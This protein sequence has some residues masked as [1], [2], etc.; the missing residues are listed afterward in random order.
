MNI[1]NTYNDL[2]KQCSEFINVENTMTVAEVDQLIDI[3]ISVRK[4]NYEDGTKIRQSV[5]DDYS[6]L[7]SPSEQYKMH[8][9]WAMTTSYDDFKDVII[10][11]L[12]DKSIYNNIMHAIELDKL[13][14]TISDIE[15]IPNE[16][17]IYCLRNFD[18]CREQY[19]DE[20][21][22]P[23][24][25]KCTNPEL[26][27]VNCLSVCNEKSD[28][29]IKIGQVSMPCLRLMPVK[30]MV[31]E[32]ED[33]LDQI[34]SY[35]TTRELSPLLGAKRNLVILSGNCKNQAYDYAD[36]KNTYI[37][38]SQFCAMTLEFPYLCYVY[39][40][41]VSLDVEVDK[42]IELKAFVG[43]DVIQL[44]NTKI[45]PN[46]MCRNVKKHTCKVTAPGPCTYMGL[47]VGFSSFAMVGYPRV[48]GRA[49]VL[50]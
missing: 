9:K 32:G 4:L 34:Y 28:I 8:L 13:H 21:E 27:L 17:I 44:Q 14:F 24:A 23:K 39:P 46:N 37:Y 19:D 1:L 26:F 35:Y 11:N 22:V 49:V 18:N 41:T 16:F 40:E 48:T 12:S 2:K 47:S 43:T 42:D 29:L 20:E 38:S 25:P 50:V 7:F 33:L 36:M 15:Q 3:L 30:Y 10:Q 6:K 31:F 5:R 45:I